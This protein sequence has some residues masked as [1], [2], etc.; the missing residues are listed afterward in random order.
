MAKL[1]PVVRGA[2]SSG[3]PQ[4]GQWACDWAACLLVRLLLSSTLWASASAC[5]RVPA[6]SSVSRDPLPSFSLVRG[7][8]LPLSAMPL[9]HPHP[10]P[11]SQPAPAAIRATALPLFHPPGV[12][13][14]PSPACPQATPTGRQSAT[15]RCA[16]GGRTPSPARR[17]SPCTTWS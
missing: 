6:P 1:D 4:E 3:S 10:P 11:L 14:P 12:P 15:A 5:P 8:F 2:W 17:P 7:V 16:C 13:L 9:S